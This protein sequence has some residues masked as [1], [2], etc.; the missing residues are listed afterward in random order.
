[1][2]IE[3]RPAH[4]T[5]T[6]GAVIAF[7]SIA[8]VVAVWL[9]ATYGVEDSRV[10]ER[11]V[12]L[13]YFGW[14]KNVP[15]LYSAFGLLSTGLLLFFISAVTKKSQ[16]PYGRHWFFLGLIFVF[17]CADEAFEL[18][19]HLVTPSRALLGESATGFFYYAW[20][21]PYGIL[22]II[23][24]I[25]Y[26]KFFLAMP[27]AFFVRCVISG[28]VFVGGAIGVEGLGGAHDEDFGEDTQLSILATIEETL[29][30]LGVL[31]FIDALCRYLANE[32]PG[33]RI[34]IAD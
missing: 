33:A 25:A 15:S 10:I 29:E 26:L 19:E 1:M 32:L 18:H 27:R 17:L 12:S 34:G 31:I 22:V 14:E 24:G 16:R 4:V 3:I 21:I 9:L 30:M 7:I 2:N 6:Y 11:Y 8:N 23:L 13:F 20:I 28:I 5:M